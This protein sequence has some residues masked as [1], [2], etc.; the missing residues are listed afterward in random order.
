MDSSTNAFDAESGHSAGATVNLALRSGTNAIKANVSYFNRDSSRTSTPLLTQRAGADKPPRQYNRG[1]STIS[2]PIIKDRTFF[3]FSVERLR[4]V[5]AEPA[6]YT[7]P[8]MKMR[9]GDLSEFSTLVYDPLT[10][11]GSNLT[12]KAFAGPALYHLNAAAGSIPQ[13]WS[14]R[15]K[16][17]E[18]CAK[19]V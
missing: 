13:V 9:Q 18:P 19:I 3:M 12:R 4:D 16:N 8:T 5:N 6:T 7:V 15:E 11:T 10:A 14:L 2:G 17:H 1:T